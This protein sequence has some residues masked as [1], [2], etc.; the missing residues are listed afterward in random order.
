LETLA[1][2]AAVKTPQYQREQ[3]FITLARLF[4]GCF[5]STGCDFLTQASL[6]SF[7]F[8][9]GQ[10]QKIFKKGIDGPIIIWD[11]EQC[12]IAL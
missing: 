3:V 1:H 7:A 4:T 6:W 11:Y 5:S 2:A 9:C 10:T 8:L 12:R